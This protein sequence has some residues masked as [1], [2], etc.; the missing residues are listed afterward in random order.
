MGTQMAEIITIWQRP[1]QATNCEYCDWTFLTELDTPLGKCPHCYRLE[2]TPLTEEDLPEIFKPELMLPFNLPE[3]QIRDHLTKFSKSYWLPPKD[4]KSGLLADRLQRIYIPA[5]LVDSE[6]EAVWQAEVGFNY[7]VV[8]HQESYQQ[9]SWVTR[10]VK[11]VKVR[12]EPRAGHLKRKYEN[13]QAPAIEEVASLKEKLGTFDRP[14]AGPYAV[15]ALAGA[16]VRLPNRNPVDAWPDAQPAFQKQASEECQS[17]AAAQHIRQ[18]GWQPDFSAQNWTLLLLP[19][20][21]TYYLDDDGQPLPILLNGRTGQISGTKKASM[22]RAKKYARNL[23]ILAAVLFL[24]TL[25]LLLLRPNL[26]LF[27]L[28]LTLFIGLG[29]IVPIAQASRFNRSQE[30]EIPFTNS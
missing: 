22:K 27:T 12:W 18:Y 4:L 2:L 5:W 20:Y 11:E 23:A 7:E 26:A 30:F 24:A 17:A 25:A 3:E 9:S 29:A 14:N 28:I 15:G 6:V 8:S 21:S 13:I 19:I 10:E 16:L 1:L